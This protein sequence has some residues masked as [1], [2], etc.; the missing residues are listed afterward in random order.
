MRSGTPMSKSKLTEEI[1]KDILKLH[2]YNSMIH[3]CSKLMTAAGHYGKKAIDPERQS[4]NYYNKILTKAGFRQHIPI[5]L[6][7]ERQMT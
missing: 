3:F 6:A 4:Y 5:L 1:N 2:D 7:L